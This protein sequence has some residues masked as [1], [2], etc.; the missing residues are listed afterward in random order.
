MG[1]IAYLDFALLRFVQSRSLAGST[2]SLQRK[3]NAYTDAYV[4]A[5]SCSVNIDENGKQA[6]M[7]LA[8]GDLRR[9]LN[10][11]QVHITSL[12]AFVIALC[13]L[14]IWP[15]IKLT[16]RSST[17]LLELLCHQS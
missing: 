11:L 14:H 12:Y 3:G 6:I 15:T 7:R 13:S 9:V 4:C 5:N 8:N 16:K 10:L 17:T 2:M 1:L